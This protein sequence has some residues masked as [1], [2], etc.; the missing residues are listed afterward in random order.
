MCHVTFRVVLYAVFGAPPLLALVRS[1]LH[2]TLHIALR[3]TLPTEAV[4]NLA[5]P[6]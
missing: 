1:A 4:P 2:S 6:I 3:V 5:R